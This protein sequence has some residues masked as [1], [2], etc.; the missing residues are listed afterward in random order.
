MWES[1]LSGFKLHACVRTTSCSDQSASCEDSHVILWSCDLVNPA[2]LQG[3]TV[4][5]NNRQMVHLV[6][7][8]VSACSFPNSFRW[9]CVTNHLV[10]QFSLNL[11]CRTSGSESNYLWR[12]PHSCCSLLAV[13]R[14]IHFLSIT[15][16][17]K[18]F[19]SLSEFDP[20]GPITFGKSRKATRLNHFILIKVSGRLIRMIADSTGAP[21]AT[22]TI[23]CWCL[24]MT[25]P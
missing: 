20:F 17:V 2:A 18:W 23:F 22:W 24:L 21:W 15:T 14:W 13:K 12:I 25:P 7:S 11:Q 4:R 1:I 16:G 9:F 19:V 6:T 5:D 10:C 3:K 8:Q